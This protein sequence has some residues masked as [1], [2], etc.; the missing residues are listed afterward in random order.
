[1]WSVLSPLPAL[2]RKGFLLWVFVLCGGAAAHGGA[3]D[4]GAPSI[5]VEVAELTQH[6][7][8]ANCGP[9]AAAMVLS[10]AG[11]GADPDILRDRIGTWSW[12]RFPLRALSVS[13]R[14]SGMTSP[15]MMAEVLEAFGGQGRF[16]ALRHPFLPGDA[17]ALLA[18]RSALSEGRPVLMMVE[19]PILWGTEQAGLHWI[20]VRGA[21]RDTFIFNDPADGKE[22]RVST[23]RL[24]RAWRLHPL[25]RRLPGVEAFTAF[26]L[27]A[28]L[29]CPDDV[30]R[31]A[32]VR[33]PLRECR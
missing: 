11:I 31:I 25:W 24:W 18:L 32:S 20:V 17:F 19:S 15:T 26:V 22:H 1:M 9:T 12:G 21:E 2:I 8:V 16:R 29:P 30:M 6:G 5:K 4:G 14:S 3:L 27:D 7:D 23:E 33:R 28:P 10:H 13:G